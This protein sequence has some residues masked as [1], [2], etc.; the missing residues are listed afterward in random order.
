MRG[1]CHPA[2]SQ[3]SDPAHDL[4]EVP[5]PA[6]GDGSRSERAE[7]VQKRPLGL[8][9]ARRGR[10]MLPLV[11]EGGHT[12]VPASVDLSGGATPLADVFCYLGDKTQ[13]SERL[14]V[15]L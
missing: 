13:C 7:L 11:Q 14:L 3:L 6:H 1:G 10:L 2:P 9:A 12:L 15:L 8:E 5:Q 4:S